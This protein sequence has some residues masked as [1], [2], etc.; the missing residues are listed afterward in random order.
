MLNKNISIIGT[1]KITTH[2]ITAAKKVGFKIYALAASRRNSK[3]LMP[4]AKK[5]KIKRIFYSWKDCINKSIERYKDIS[6]VI[7]TP[8]TKNKVI[9]NYIMK[10][11]SKILIEKPV[12][13][14]P[15]EFT[16]LNKNRKN[17]FVGFNRIFYK[18]I[19]YLKL[20]ITKRKNLNVVCN[21]PEINNKF[22][23][24]NSC[25]IF[26]ILYFVF[27]NLKFIKKIKN[28]NF[29]N[30]HLVSKAAQINIFFNFKASE[31]F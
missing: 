19:N 13:N 29:I 18:N 14:T 21:I 31:N 28:K 24:S 5:H 17:I 3:Y 15:N 11:N 6:F 12:F 8:T 22:I 30:V 4:L 16:K 1:S 26:S 9:L 10:H 27:G 7:T 23:S 20:K 25:H 2:H